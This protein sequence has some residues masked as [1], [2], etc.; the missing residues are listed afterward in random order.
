LLIELE[1]ATGKPL[2]P[3]RLD[4]ETLDLAARLEPEHV[5]TPAAAA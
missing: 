5:L 3:A 1:R 4:D 2:E